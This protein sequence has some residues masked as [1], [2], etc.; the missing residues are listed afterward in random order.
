M[1]HNNKYYAEIMGN[2]YC[3]DLSPGTVGCGG[4]VIYKDIVIGPFNY[5]EQN[6][7][8]QISIGR[9]WGTRGRKGV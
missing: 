4:R 6:G 7:N 1:L 8:L 9:F 3:L 2:F 5:D